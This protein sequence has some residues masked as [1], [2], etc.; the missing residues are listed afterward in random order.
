MKN[1]SE[2]RNHFRNKVENHC[3]LNNHKKSV[4][5]IGCHRHQD[6]VNYH[7]HYQVNER[8]PKL[9]WIAKIDQDRKQIKVIHGSLVECRDNWMVEGIWD[10][11]FEKGNFHRSENFYG[12]G[13]RIEDNCVYVSISASPIDRPLFCEYKDNLIFSNSF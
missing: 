12:S 2:E 7:F 6:R 8:L 9:A 3:L 5:T 10:D 13:I 11:Q 4:S 1:Q